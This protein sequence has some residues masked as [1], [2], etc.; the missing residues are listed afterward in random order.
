MTPSGEGLPND[1]SRLEGYLRDIAFRLQL[2][3]FLEFSLLLSSGLGLILLGSLVAL[4]FKETFPYLSFIYCVIAIIFLLSFGLLGLRK[5]VWKPSTVRVAVELEQKFPQL[6]DDV[7]N[8]L[9]LFNQIKEG[10]SSGQISH[11]LIMAQVKRTAAEVY[12]IKPQEVVSFRKVLRH[13]R[14]LLPLILAFSV[15]LAL[16][17]SFLNRSLALITHPLSTLPQEKTLLSVEP[18]GSVVLRGT[19]V[20]IRAKASGKMPDKL[21]LA[22]WPERREG[23]RLNM[24][25]EGNGRFS[26][27]ISSV[28]SSFRYRVESSRV[29]SPVYS[30]HV[31]D[32]P[33]VGKLKVTLIAPDYTGLP[34]EIRQEGHIEA[35]KG[36]VLNLEAETTKTVK[37][38]K[39]V[40]NQGN[41]FALQVKGDRLVGSW[42]IFYPGSYSIKVKD[43][44]GFENQNPVEYQIRLIPDKYPEGEITSPG[45]DLEISG[46]EVIPILYTAKDDFGIASIK[47]NY[48][49]GEKEH[50][51]PLKSSGGRSLGPET[52][53]WDLGSLALAPRDR[54]TYR[55]EV[56]DNDSVSG[57]KKGYSRVFNLSVRDEKAI[58]AKEGEEAQ[59]IV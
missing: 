45:Q 32:P 40:L 28:Q 36:T 44:L 52:Y 1:Y 48:Q 5:V 26:Y 37:E 49:M 50:S 53:R 29:A 17:P 24:D 58:A 54:V 23:I 43:E 57:P 10:S 31:V 13:L 39:V 19:P 20:I 27:Q 3:S 30:I 59:K 6:R 8:S 47:L 9:L 14:L 51:I 4:E 34:K 16:D 35:L 42:P 11:K 46:N 22:I 55:L 56:Q 25:P 21:A 15:V 2:L 33:D 41:Q 38:G 18:G 12:A 7:T